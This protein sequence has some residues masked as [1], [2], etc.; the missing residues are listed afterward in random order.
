MNGVEVPIGGDVVI[1]VDGKPVIHFSDLL[2]EIAFR[3]P[4]TRTISTY[5]TMSTDRSPDGGNGR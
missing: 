4:T 1:E 3:Q 5:E 2:V